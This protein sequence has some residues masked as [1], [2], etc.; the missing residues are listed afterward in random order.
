MAWINVEYNSNKSA[1]KL[2]LSAWTLFFVVQQIIPF[3][4]NKNHNVLKHSA[5]CVD[6]N[7]FSSFSNNVM[8]STLKE[9]DFRD[10]NKLGIT[11]NNSQFILKSKNIFCFF[12]M[13][14]I[15]KLCVWVLRSLKRV[16]KSVY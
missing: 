10:F 4:F 3:F 5:R 9:S 16:N 7:G 8:L 15:F 1:I 6:L 13:G 12:Q 11:A 2:G 14:K